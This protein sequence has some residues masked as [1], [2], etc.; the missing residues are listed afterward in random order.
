MS[1]QEG[2]TDETVKEMQVD[3]NQLDAILNNPAAKAALMG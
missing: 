3:E 1:S 2:E